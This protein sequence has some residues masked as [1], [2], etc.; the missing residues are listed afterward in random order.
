MFIIYK[1]FGDFVKCVLRFCC[2]FSMKIIFYLP[3]NTNKQQFVAFL[4]FVCTTAS[5]IAQISSSG[6]VLKRDATL[7]LVQKSERPRTFQFTGANQI[8]R[9]LLFTDLVNTNLVYCFAPIWQRLSLLSFL[10]IKYSRVISLAQETAPF[11]D[12]QYLYRWLVLNFLTSAIS[13]CCRGESW[14]RS[15]RLLTQAVYHPVYF[16]SEGHHLLIGQ[17]SLYNYGTRTVVWYPRGNSVCD[18]N[19]VWG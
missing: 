11:F 18:I 16:L 7:A 14:S 3:V 9:N 8:E 17:T 6:N 13:V 2:K 1:P 4:V 15:T 10:I 19:I 12:R 5:F